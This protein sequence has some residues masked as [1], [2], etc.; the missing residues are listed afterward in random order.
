MVASGNGSREGVGSAYAGR[1]KLPSRRFVDRARKV[2]RGD[3]QRESSHRGELSRF[4]QP[5]FHELDP[6]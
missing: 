2:P 5:I 3:S 4:F 6:L 1:D